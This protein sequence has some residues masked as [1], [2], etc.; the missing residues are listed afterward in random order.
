MFDPDDED[1]DENP[2][3]EYGEE[4]SDRDLGRDYDYGAECESYNW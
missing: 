1:N 2:C 3:N 4:L